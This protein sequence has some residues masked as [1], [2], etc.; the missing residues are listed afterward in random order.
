MYDQI[1]RTNIPGLPRL[2]GGAVGFSS[3]DTFR[4]VEHLPNTP[5]DDLGLPEAVWGFYD[6]IYAFDHVKHQV[7]LIHT[8]RI[9]SNTDDEHELQKMYAE[10]QLSLDQIKK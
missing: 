3:Y 5:N 9:E 10:A 2:I 4:E 1:Y 6:E 7:I 8:V